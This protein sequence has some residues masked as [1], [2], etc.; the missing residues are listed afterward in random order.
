LA[1]IALVMPWIV[2]GLVVLARTRK[3][4][5]LLLA[6]GE[7]AAAVGEQRL[8]EGQRLWEWRLLWTHGALGNGRPFK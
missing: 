3:G 1:G 6:A 8:W 5:K 7:S 2:K 4:R